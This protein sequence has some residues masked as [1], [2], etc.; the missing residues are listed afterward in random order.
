MAGKV[1]TSHAA[2]YHVLHDTDGK[3]LVYGYLEPRRQPE[4]HPVPPQKHFV[5][6]YGLSPTQRFKLGNK[7]TS[8]L[9]IKWSISQIEPMSWEPAS[10]IDPLTH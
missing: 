7:H 1:S 5:T 10:P 8:K 4:R 9:D 2:W 3:T 6:M